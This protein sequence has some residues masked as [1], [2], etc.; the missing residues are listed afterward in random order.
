M[1]DVA[2]RVL[3]ARHEEARIEAP[4]PAGR[5]HGASDQVET[6]ERRRQALVEEA[7][8]VLAVV[9]ARRAV[10]ERLGQHQAGL[11]EGLAHGGDAQR[12]RPLRRGSLEEP[13][14]DVSIE[15][16]GD[17]DMRIG[18]VDP[19]A[20]E[21]IAVGHE[22][23]LGGAATHQHF[24]HLALQAH[25]DQRRRIARPHVGILLLELLDRPLLA[26]RQ[27]DVAVDIALVGAAHDG[28]GGYTRFAHG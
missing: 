16:R 13:R 24:R 11:L 22:G 25:E 17:R 10:P 2:R 4:R 14:L 9:L 20:G 7:L 12:L 18:L 27:R 28:A 26:R 15:R 19:A 5:S 1:T 21:D 6:V 8:P 23:R 3:G